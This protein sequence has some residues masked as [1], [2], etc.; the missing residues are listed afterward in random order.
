MTARTFLKKGNGFINKKLKNWE[1]S[2]I[3]SLTMSKSSSRKFY[4]T[5]DNKNKKSGCQ[6]PRNKYGSVERFEETHN[7]HSPIDNYYVQKMSSLL[8]SSVAE[9]MS[10]DVAN[11][12]TTLKERYST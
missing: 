1:C 6:S 3:S 2:S 5:L 10:R 8:Q 9:T 12:L 11:R 7:S 4:D